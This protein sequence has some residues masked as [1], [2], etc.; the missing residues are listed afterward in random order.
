M[1]H[2]VPIA[3]TYAPSGWGQAPLPV[4]CKS[5]QVMGGG[6]A[7]T[8]SF[9]AACPCQSLSA[10]A[11]SFMAAWQS[12][13]PHLPALLLKNRVG[14]WARPLLA[15]PGLELVLIDKCFLTRGL[16]GRRGIR[17]GG[18]TINSAITGHH[19][20]ENFRGIGL[21]MTWAELDQRAA[22]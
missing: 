10:V 13:P 15:P 4:M 5:Q 16:E 22:P 19:H 7:V 11:C 8:W 1:G 14:G 2:E 17:V 9:M 18:W 6:T 3:I 20:L 21:G 12:S